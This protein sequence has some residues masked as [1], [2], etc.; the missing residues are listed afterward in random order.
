[1]GLIKADC[2][3]SLAKTIHRQFKRKPGSGRIASQVSLYHL[4]RLIS[5]RKPKVVLEVG[6]GIGTVSQ[7][8]LAH[9]AKVQAL[10][11]IEQEPF[12]R[13]SLSKNLTVQEWQKWVLFHSLSELPKNLRFDLII[14]DGNQYDPSIF[15]FMGA[16]TAIFVEGKRLQTREEL[17]ANCRQIGLDLHLQEHWGRW[18]IGLRGL[19]NARMRLVLKRDQC[20]F[21]ICKLTEAAAATEQPQRREPAEAAIVERA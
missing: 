7:L 5:L 3:M 13:A 2:D 1:M 15:Q 6:S 16:E 4:S 20:H 19:K 9:P 12:C 18:H 21:G 8:V 14:F 11:S 17:T 10:L